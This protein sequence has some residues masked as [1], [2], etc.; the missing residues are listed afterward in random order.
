VVAHKTYVEVGHT[1]C[2]EVGNTACVEA[3]R[4]HGVCRGSTHGV[5]SYLYVK[6]ESLLRTCLQCIDLGQGHR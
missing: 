1:A 3:Q 5:K 6:I 4:T 2:V